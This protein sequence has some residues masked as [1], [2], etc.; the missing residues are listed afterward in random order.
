MDSLTNADS[1]GSCDSVISLNSAFS[2]DSLGYLSA[3]ERACLI[4]L[5]ETIESLQAD[6]D[7]GLS[8]DEQDQL[9]HSQETNPLQDHSINES[10]SD[11]VLKVNSDQ[12]EADDKKRKRLS[13]LVPTPLLLATG[14]V[15]VLPKPSGSVTDPRPGAAEE[16]PGVPAMFS[17]PAPPTTDEL[18]EEATGS[19]EMTN[20]EDAE[21][22]TP[23][24]FPFPTPTSLSSNTCEV[25]GAPKENPQDV[26]S[27]PFHRWVS[28]EMALIPPPS[29]FMD[30]PV[31]DSE[32][33]DFVPALPPENKLPPQSQPERSETLAPRALDTPAEEDAPAAPE[34]DRPPEED[35]AALPVVDRPAEEDAPGPPVV[36]RPAEEDAPAP[37]VV[38]RPAEET[39]VHRAESLKASGVLSDSDLEKLRK[40]ASVKKVPPATDSQS[41]TDH[42]SLPLSSTDTP[43][44]THS[45]NSELRSP[46]SVAPKPKKLPPNIIL[47][48]QKTQDSKSGH[49]PVSAGERVIMDPQKVRMEAL[50]KLGLLKNDEVDSGPIPS[51]SLSPKCHR[52]RASPTSPSGRSSLTELPPGDSAQSPSLPS[53]PGPDTPTCTADAG[54]VSPL[55]LRQERKPEKTLVV[56]SPSP[57]NAHQDNNLDKISVE[58]SPGQLRKTLIHPPSP[59]DMKDTGNHQGLTQAE[60]LKRDI[61]TRVLPAAP[62]TLPHSDS[63][64]EPRSHGISV[65]ISPHSQNGE[66]RREAL[67]KLGLLRD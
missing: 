47:K 57:T 66:N 22:A 11:G 40:K 55:I 48:N 8:H 19:E 14:G 52:H 34:V 16:N 24:N 27:I 45:E 10:Q 61:G 46:P 43:P 50:R 63:S 56:K 18:T 31:G 15:N 51:P 32:P 2:D 62:P 60:L 37:P 9:R 67:K 7:S 65:V 13:C 53:E 35:A 49:L 6:D 12:D 38:D 36:D 21:L 41:N 42:S 59:S 5:E 26:G 1:A 39:K 29:D 4:F 58:L 33:P 3:E 25:D 30:G 54:R 64:K 23:T 28:S 20:H 17:D 44:V